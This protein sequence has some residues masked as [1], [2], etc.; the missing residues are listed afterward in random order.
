MI[1]PFINWIIE[2]IKEGMKIPDSVLYPIGYLI[3][4][5]SSFIYNEIM[6]FNFCGLNINTKIF[7]HQRIYI[8]KEEIKNDSVELLSVDEN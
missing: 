8:E 7:V 3:V 2:S 6:I 5:F 4:I 1:S